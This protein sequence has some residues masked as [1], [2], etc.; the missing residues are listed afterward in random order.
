MR[1]E[2]TDAYV[3]TD[4]LKVAVNAAI[5]LE[6]PLLVKG[7]ARHR[8]D[9]TGD[10][11]RQGA[12]RSSDRDG[13]IKSTTK[14]NMQGLYEYDAVTRLRDS[15]LGDARVKDIRNGTSGGASFGKRSSPTN[16]RFC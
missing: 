2:G 13:H 9:R 1:F 3:A 15:Q 11:S 10:R 4:D 8:Q 7:R 16:V 12:R 14:A 6:R 5:A